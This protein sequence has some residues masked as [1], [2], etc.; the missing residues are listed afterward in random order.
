MFI[1]LSHTWGSGFGT[2]DHISSGVLEGLCRRSLL[3]LCPRY[4]RIELPVVLS[5]GLKRAPF[6]TTK[7]TL[8]LLE[9]QSFGSD[10]AA[11]YFL[12]PVFDLSRGHLDQRRLLRCRNRTTTT[13]ARATGRAPALW[14]TIG[15][16][17]LSGFHLARGAVQV[18]LRTCPIFSGA[19]NRLG[20]RG[21][22]NRWCHQ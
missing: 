10:F 20:L 9:R 3:S 15:P 18:A 8:A 14:S 2:L 22:N 16:H 1:S 13:A 12:R 5:M 6:L 19:R 21:Y 7:Y 4:V 17:L 11:D